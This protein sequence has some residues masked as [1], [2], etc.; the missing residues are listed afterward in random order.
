MPRRLRLPAPPH[1]CEYREAIARVQ[2][3]LEQAQ[4]MHGRN[5]MVSSAKV[6]D[7][8]N[9]RG[10]WRY[11]DQATEPMPKMD[12]DTEDL[13]PIT[14]CKSVAARQRPVS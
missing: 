13:D 11:I 6:L 1:T 5:I 9:P 7:L 3:E 4:A 8:L 12:G 2:I 10:M 14:G